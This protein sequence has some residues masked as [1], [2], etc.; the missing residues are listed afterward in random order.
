[1]AIFTME[2]GTKVKCMVKVATTISL[3]ITSIREN[4]VMES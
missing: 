1:V 2:I 4:F 3:R